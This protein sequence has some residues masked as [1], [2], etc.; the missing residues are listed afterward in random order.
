MLL[1]HSS[2]LV[3]LASLRESQTLLNAE[4]ENRIVAEQA[5]KTFMEHRALR[6]ITQAAGVGLVLMGVSNIGQPGLALPL[7]VVGAI[8]WVTAFLP[9]GSRASQNDYLSKHIRVGNLGRL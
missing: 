4:R 5:L 7:I 6:E 1:R 3:C 9:E 8:I 2:L